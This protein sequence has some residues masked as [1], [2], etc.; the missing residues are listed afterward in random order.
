MSAI[1]SEAQADRTLTMLREG[2]QYISNRCERYGSDVFETRI[3]GRKALC[4]K[5]EEATRLLYD[6]ERF[7][8]RKATPPRMLKT[9]LGA[10]GVQGLDG[11][12]HRVR[13]QLWLDITT[14][15]NVER[16]AALAADEWRRRIPGWEAR[17]QIVLQDESAE[18]FCRAVCTWAGVPLADSR[19]ARTAAMLGWFLDSVGRVG[20]RYVRGR[21]ARVRLE[22]WAERVITDARAG[23]LP[24]PGPVLDRIASH[25]DLD[26]QRLA[27]RI[28][29]VELLTL[30]RTTTA[31]SWF[32]ADAALALHQH[33]EWPDRLQA[34][35]PAERERF[36]QEVRRYF[37]LF[38]F[39]VARVRSA[40]DW[41]GYHFPAGRFVLLDVY[42]TNPD[43]RLWKCPGEFRPEHFGEWDRGAFNFIPHGG[44]DPAH[45]HRCPGEGITIALM[46]TAVEML[47]TAMDYDV[48]PQD[49]SVRMSPIPTMPTSRF[50]IA[51]V[52][53]RNPAARA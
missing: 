35:D 9:L 45:G 18:I 42:G 38:P 5:G 44:G 39:V 12:P 43:P 27:P 51:N 26:G 28:A 24:A 41:R 10:G 46:A 31:V 52:R 3:L 14:P 34:G 47:T 49:L 16:L 48:P 30:L 32:V 7:T 50:V 21:V 53:A 20:P 40:F 37:P 36:V 23:R 25:R 8:R 13:K 22:R 6:E 11:E 19:V 29:A 4:M 1:P 33:P 2:Y 17:P 15:D